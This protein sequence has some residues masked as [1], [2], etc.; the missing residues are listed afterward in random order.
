[1]TATQILNSGTLDE[2]SFWLLEQLVNRTHPQ[3]TTVVP[4]SGSSPRPKQQPAPPGGAQA[5]AEPSE[6]PAT[7]KSKPESSHGNSSYG[8]TEAE[9]VVGFLLTTQE[10]RVRL[11]VHRKLCQECLT[12]EYRPSPVSAKNLGNHRCPLRHPRCLPRHSRCPPRQPRCLPRPPRCPLRHPRCPP[13]HPRCPLRHPRCLPRH[14]RCPLRR[15]R[16]PLKSPRCPPRHHRC[17]QR[18]TCCPR[19]QTKGLQRSN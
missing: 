15:H 4:G 1:M 6:E 13:R 5:K 11:V 9:V 8:S 18:Q 7:E 19:R 2:E 10:D 14:P 12:L 17:L 16:C 3:Q